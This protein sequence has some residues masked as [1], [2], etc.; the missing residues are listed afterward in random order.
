MI[1]IYIKESDKMVEKQ[2]TSTTTV[3]KKAYGRSLLGF[4]K[5]IKLLRKL[6]IK[7]TLQVHP[8]MSQNKGKENNKLFYIRNTFLT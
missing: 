8:L 4:N 2:R 6:A 1:K 5:D 7:Y 3:E